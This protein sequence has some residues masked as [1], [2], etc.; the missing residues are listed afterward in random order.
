MPQIVSAILQSGDP[1]AALG[2]FEECQR[3]G[4]ECSLKVYCQ[5][6]IALS[7]CER[8][9]GRH[10]ASKSAYSL[11]QALVLSKQHHLDAA[12]YR[13]G[14]HTYHPPPPLPVVACAQGHIAPCPVSGIGASALQTVSLLPCGWCCVTVRQC[15]MLC[16]EMTA[17]HYSM[18]CSKA[19]LTVQLAVQSLS[20]R[21]TLHGCSLFFVSVFSWGPNSSARTWKSRDSAASHGESVQ[22]GFDCLISVRTAGM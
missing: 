11:W 13:A 20:P 2:V 9:H 4:H 6:I 8:P 12:A 7:K 14:A 3:A 15:N 16:G 19:L 18:L 17:S 22:T 10:A 1:K 5:L 21:N